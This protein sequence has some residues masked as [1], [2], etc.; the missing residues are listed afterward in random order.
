[1][2]GSGP[3]TLVG[4]FA[5]TQKNKFSQI[6]FWQ[7]MFYLHLTMNYFL[8]RSLWPCVVTLPWVI[9]H[10]PINFTRP[11]DRCAL[12]WPLSRWRHIRW[13][14]VS[15]MTSSRYQLLLL[16]SLWCR[17]GGYSFGLVRDEVPENFGMN[18]PTQFRQLA[19]RHVTLV[20]IRQS[21][22]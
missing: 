12:S 1:M 9:C 17:Y 21:F 20:S 18:G 19:V 11:A 16:M 13:C 7:Q 2:V 22:L 8:S 14:A 3:Q 15:Y 6:K 10:R 4:V 5:P